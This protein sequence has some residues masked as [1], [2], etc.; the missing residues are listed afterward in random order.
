MCTI[1]EKVLIAQWPNCPV[2]LN[3][4]T[5]FLRTFLKKKKKNWEKKHWGTET[6]F[7]Y[8]LIILMDSILYLLG[9]GIS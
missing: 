2:I 4:L 9:L 6:F 3:K 7:A 8:V 1:T 5:F